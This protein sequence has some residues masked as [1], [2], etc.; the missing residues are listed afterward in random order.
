LRA[1]SIAMLRME[2]AGHGKA[3]LDPYAFVPAGLYGASNRPLE[4]GIERG[5]AIPRTGESHVGFRDLDFG[6]FGADTFE[7]PLFIMENEPLP[8]EVWE[9]MPNECGR[10]IADFT[11]TLGS[12]WGGIS[13]RRLYASQTAEGHHH[14]VFRLPPYGAHQRISIL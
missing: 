12:V 5:V 10:K 3:T 1:V 4:N 2:I 8:F 6:D 7:L 13:N 11:Y 9:G 14:A